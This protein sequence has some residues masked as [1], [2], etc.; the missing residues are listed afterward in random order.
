MVDVSLVNDVRQ[1][2]ERTKGSNPKE[3]K[4]KKK[5]EKNFPSSS[6]SSSSV[7]YWRVSKRMHIFVFDTRNLKVHKFVF[8]A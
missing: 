8:R 7:V 2:F 5:T 1:P 6:S 3:K 4:K